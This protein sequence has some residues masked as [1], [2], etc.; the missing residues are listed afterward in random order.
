LVERQGI[1]EAVEM[2][3]DEFDDSGD[4]IDPRYIVSFLNDAVSEDRIVLHDTG[5]HQFWALD[6]MEVN[7]PADFIW[8]KDFVGVGEGV[9][10]ALGAALDESRTCVLICGDGGIMMSLQEIETAARHDIPIVIAV[11]NDRALGAEYQRVIKRRLP[12]AGSQ[13]E[14]PDLGSVADSLGLDGHTIREPADLE[15]LEEKL[16]P[17]PDGPIL[18]NCEVS[19]EVLSPRGE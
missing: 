3:P 1:A 18:L 11:M 19:R 8:T 7:D 5:Y 13:I 16:D 9:K 15:G 2:D 14:T 6:G 12:T 17:R 10:M 4:R